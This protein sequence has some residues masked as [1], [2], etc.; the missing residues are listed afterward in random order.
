MEITISFIF[1]WNYES[2]ILYGFWTPIYGIGYLIILFIYTLVKVKQKK[3]INQMVCLFII[4]GIALALIEYIGGATIELIFNTSFWDYSDKVFNIGKYT[5]LEMA[6]L[7]AF[8]SIIIIYLIKPFLD[9]IINKIPKII[10]AILI[11]LF[12][13]DLFF[14]LIL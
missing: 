3:I 8:S 6:S 11:L 12:S 2:G 1:N 10:T 4:S 7:W 9:K 14:T 5:S 13:L